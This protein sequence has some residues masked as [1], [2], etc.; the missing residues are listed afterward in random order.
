MV[1]KSKI[2]EEM[3][4]VCMI[5]HEAQEFENIPELARASKRFELDGPISGR[6]KPCK[7]NQVII[8]ERQRSFER[9]RW[10]TLERDSLDMLLEWGDRFLGFS[11]SGRTYKGYKIK[12]EWRNQKVVGIEFPGHSASIYPTMDIYRVHRLRK[13][14]LEGQGDNPP[15]WTL[16][17][18]GEEAGFENIV[19]VISHVLCYG[20]MLDLTRIDSVAPTVD[21][22]R[23][24]EPSD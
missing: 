1:G 19:R 12:F 21:S 2:P 15:L 23:G 5:C 4:I 8:D 14:G 11:L 6:F 18:D 10:N 24:N 17:L 9:D 20:Y 7:P 3:H 22:K 13:M 16:Q